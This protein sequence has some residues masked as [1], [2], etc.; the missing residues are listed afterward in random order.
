MTHGEP[1]LRSEVGFA[2]P[3]VSKLNLG[4][5]DWTVEF[6]YQPRKGSDHDGV[7]LEI[8]TGPRGENDRVTQLLLNANRESFT[9]V[10]QPAGVHLK[11]PSNAVALTVVSTDWHHMAFVYDASSDQLKH[12]VDGVLQPLPEKCSLKPLQA[13]D[14]DYLSLGRD[15]H[16]QRPLPGCIDELRISD[17]QVYKENFQPPHSFSKLYAETYASPKLQAGPPLLFASEESADAV[18]PLGGRKYLFIDDVLVKESENVTFNVNPPRR[19]ERVLDHVQGHL[20]IFDDGT[21]VVRL[22]YKG[23]KDSLAVL[24]SRDG[25][26]WDISDLGNSY[27]GA[28]NI[29]IEDPV[30]MG[31]IFVDPNAPPD[32]RIK[33]I[34]GFRGRGCYIYTSPD[35]YHFRR[36]ETSRAAVS[37]RV[38]VNRV[39]RRAAADLRGFSSHRHAGDGR[40]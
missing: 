10:S 6:W 3:T 31:T 12:Y 14:E 36:N 40:W 5:S 13:G 7:V 19:A 35:G 26:H 28:S 9:L 39:L 18:V 15:A 30:G 1:H 38:A 17:D 16:W 23:P 32:E 20:V 25:V 2:S 4:N 24:T 8:G 22:Y 29:V 33:Y 34:S 27:E 11:I 21:D 37:G